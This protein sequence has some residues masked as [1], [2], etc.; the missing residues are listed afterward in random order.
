MKALSIALSLLCFLF[1]SAVFAQFA[2]ESEVGIV[3]TGGNTEL[4]VYNGKT[5]NTYTAGRNT[6]TLGGHYMYGTSFNVENSRNWDI[7]AKADHGFSEK[8]G[9]FLGTVYEGDQFAGIDNRLNGDLGASYKIYKS[10]KAQATGEA[11]YRYRRE[12][13]LAGT[14]LSQSQGRVYLEGK[15][16]PSKDITLKFWTEYL[17]NF[18]DSEDWQINF[19]PS[20]QYNFMSNLALKWGYMG[21]YDNLPVPGNKKFDFTYMTSLIANF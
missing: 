11:G 1:S 12:E 15:R 9:I 4:E 19:E 18:T 2:N 21:R 10:E 5:K 14:V 8:I 17:P 3:V 7:N 16:T 6:F 20:F 13:N